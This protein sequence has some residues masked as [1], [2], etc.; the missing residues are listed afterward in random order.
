MTA[1]S[2]P[3][4]VTSRFSVLERPTLS[5]GKCAVCGAVDREVV[6]FGL[7]IQRYGAIMLC[8]TCVCEAADRVGM[9][10]PELLEE[11]KVQ[12]GQSIE[13]YLMQRNLKVITYELYDSLTSLVGRF[14]AHPDIHFSDVDSNPDATNEG[15]G[16]AVPGQLQL[17]FSDDE[18]DGK[19]S[20]GDTEAFDL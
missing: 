20:D 19:Q 15:D 18:P 7:N 13:G 8:V 3:N 14:S 4:N 2:V 12:T 6:S 9:V 16:D 17:V 10:R 5:P 11:N 1:P